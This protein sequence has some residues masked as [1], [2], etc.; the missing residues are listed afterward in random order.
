[1]IVGEHE[2]H[3]HTEAMEQP[4]IVNQFVA[5]VTFGKVFKQKTVWVSGPSSDLQNPSNRFGL[6]CQLV[7]LCGE[8][9]GFFCLF[10]AWFAFATLSYRVDRINALVDWAVNI[11]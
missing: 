7:S 9:F 2:Q 11:L 6:C 4:S 1:M 10:W 8:V 3:N 5:L